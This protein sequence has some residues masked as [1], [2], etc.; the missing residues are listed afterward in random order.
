MNRRLLWIGLAVSLALNLSF[1]GVWGYSS[2]TANETIDQGHE[3]IDQ[4]ADHLLLTS[5]QRDGLIQ[6]RRKARERWRTLSGGGAALREAVIKGLADPVYD[7]AAMREIVAGRLGQRAQ[8]IAGIMGDLHGYV[9]TLSPEQRD[10]FIG[11]A[12]QRGFLRGLFGAR[13]KPSQAN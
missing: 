5:E 2:V 7:E 11:L 4:V 3:L 10:A 1:V 6:V 9:A 13:R 8:V 12:G